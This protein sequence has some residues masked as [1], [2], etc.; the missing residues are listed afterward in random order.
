MAVMAEAEG[1]LPALTE[2]IFGRFRYPVS[3][4]GERLWSNCSWS[5]RA[6]ATYVRITETLLAEAEPYDLV[7]VYLGGPDVAGHRFWRYRFPSRFKHPPTREQIANFGRVIEDCYAYV[8]GIVGRLISQA[9][10][11]VR[12]IVVSDHGM[13]A[14]N[15]DGEF[16]PNDRPSNV[17]SGHHL[18]AESGV[19][20]A[21]GAGHLPGVVVEASGAAGAVRSARAG[22]CAGYRPD[23]VDPD[24]P[25]PGRRFRR[26]GQR[27][28]GRARLAGGSLGSHR[29]HARQRGVA[30]GSPGSAGPSPRA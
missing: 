9:G 26:Q 14:V 22:Q 4:L 5:F 27:E 21:G 8:D 29:S 25:T 23:G 7:M 16:D 10:V 28:V 30:R 3:A 20:L 11:G 1:S 19:I 17:M 15:R 18:V 2:G 12:V 6:D 24:E 13:S